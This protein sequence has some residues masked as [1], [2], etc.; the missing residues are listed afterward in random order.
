MKALHKI[1]AIVGCVFL[2]QAC[3][4][5]SSDDTPKDTPKVTIVDTAIAN[6]NFTI[7]VDAL[8]AAGLDTTLADTTQQFTVFAP[9][10]AAF[11]LLGQDTLDNLLDSNN[12]DTLS[13]ILTYH[14]ISGEVDQAAAISL[15]GTTVETLSGS[16][17]GLSLD[18]NDLLINTA[19][20]TMTNIQTDNGIIHVIDAVLMPPETAA[21]PTMNIVE[22]AIA[23]GS[24]TTLVT[25]LQA[26]NLVGAL[27]DETAD[28][29][30][31]APTDAAFDML[32][33]ETVDLLLDNPDVLSAILQQ[34]VLTSAVDSITAFSLN[35]NNATT[36]SGA[37]IPV[38]INSTSDMLTYGGANIVLK[39]IHTTNGIIHVID[40]VVVADVDIPPRPMSVVGIAAASDDFTILEAALV[41]T[42][43]DSVL[44]DSDGSFTVFAP[45]DAAFA[46]LGQAKID[47]LLAAPDQLSN[48]LLYHVI[49][50]AQI[51]QD[52]AV[53]VAQSDDKKITMTNEQMATLSLTG[54]DL[55]INTSR[56][57]AANIMADNGVIHV[58]DQVILPPTVKDSPT[59]N[60]VDVV[61]GDDDFSTLASALTMANL[62]D[63]LNNND[64]TFT[65]FAPTN[66]AF[67]KIESTALTDL[68]A[69]QTQL[70]NVLLQHV[71]SGAEIS[72][73]DA[74]AANG[75]SVNTEANNDV[76]VNIVNFAQTADEATD[77]VAYH[78]MYELLVGGMNSSNSGMT[79]Y[80]FDNDLGTA[81][82][83]CN[84]TCAANWPPVLV[85][86]GEVD[87]I[88][89]LSLITRDDNT[90]QAA[91]LGRPL[92]FY[93]GDTEAGDMNGQG[94]NDVWW[95]VKQP[96]VS[97]QI[98]GSNVITKDI[99]TT[100]GVI[101]IIDTVITETLE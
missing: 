89:G 13:N 42:G 74:F 70:S 31:F 39:D 95:V 33:S 99:Y 87:N 80:V 22:T 3:G 83:T 78:A 53:T 85:T 47:E 2:L 25:A 76:T 60:I 11:Q 34:H 62:V 79:L 71:I 63:T 93:V 9:T 96:Q 19:T 7:L 51:M 10:D 36:L 26:T 84:D 101:H 12:V 41:A 18:G 17:V 67:A 46:L 8:V 32:G 72:S 1:I 75:T 66:D 100:N 94:V 65:V 59:M 44:D 57:S 21:A 15:A 98:Q 35:G 29:T 56:V 88:P 68:L 43:L 61:V 40:M 55:Y 16:H 28:Y 97:L 49:S 4:G 45:T 20:V 14:V 81:G 23:N 50:D 37:M 6:G 58:V 30:V 27:E 77:E 64:A 86:D 5:S 69:N 82:S 73:L 52:T 38:A 90:M 24:F 48:I 91:Y 54:S 92:Y